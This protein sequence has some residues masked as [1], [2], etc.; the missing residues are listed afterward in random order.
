M[1][2]VVI[3]LAGALV[4]TLG[5][6]ASQE[7]VW[8][9]L[10]GT[11]LY[12]SMIAGTGVGLLIKYIWDKRLIFAYRPASATHDFMTF[13]LYAAMGIATTAIFW[14]VEL[15]FWYTFQTTTMRYVGGVIGLGIGYWAKY[16]LDKRFVFG[17][18]P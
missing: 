1:N 12:Y 10:G 13:L 16:R 8:R 6:V 5:N 7:V 3:Y 4:A 14:A 17:S 9:L 2:L 11:G 15:A 18:Q